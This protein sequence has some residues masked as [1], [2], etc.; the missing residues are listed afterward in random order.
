M[1]E[2]HRL[3]FAPSK[4]WHPTCTNF[5]ISCFVSIGTSSISMRPLPIPAC[6]ISATV[7]SSRTS[8]SSDSCSISFG[9]V[10]E[11]SV[12]VASPGASKVELLLSS[13]VVM[14]CYCTYYCCDIL[15]AATNES[16]KVQNA[17]L[18]ATKKRQHTFPS[19]VELKLYCTG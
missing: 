17:R 9:P 2:E 18:C 10:Q 16:T 12:S 3:P 19:T 5:L 1:L 7:G 15:C 11:S 13:C 4:Q 8:S 6:L 14:F